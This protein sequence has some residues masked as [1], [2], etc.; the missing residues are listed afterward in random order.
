MYKVEQLNSDSVT[1]R[2][3]DRQTFIYATVGFSIIFQITEKCLCK[4]ANFLRT[5]DK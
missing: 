1:G 2:R 4:D 5:R 3:T